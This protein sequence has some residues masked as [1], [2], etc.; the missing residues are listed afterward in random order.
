MINPTA[1]IA[2]PKM[3]VERMPKRSAARPIAMPP[4]EAPS[5]ASE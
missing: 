1:I 2:E 4:K 5:H 3:T